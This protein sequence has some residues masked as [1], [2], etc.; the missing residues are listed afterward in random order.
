MKSTLEETNRKLTFL[1]RLPLN[2][3]LGLLNCPL[4]LVLDGGLVLGDPS[5][6]RL[7][8]GGRRL[9]GACRRATGGGFSGNGVEDAR[10][11]GVGGGTRSC[12]FCELW[13]VKK[14]VAVLRT[15]DL[16]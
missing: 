16:E 8:P 6:S 11:G 12:H 3:A 15:D 2:D 7:A 5:R 4:D 10:A 9:L 14:L 1:P 13:V